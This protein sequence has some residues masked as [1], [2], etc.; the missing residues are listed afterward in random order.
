MRIANI[1]VPPWYPNQPYLSV[2]LITGILRDKGYYVYQKDINLS[3]YDNLLS[4][5]EIKY[6]YDIYKKNK[7][8]ISQNQQLLLDLEKFLTN[9]TEKIKQKIRD[10]ISYKDKDYVDNLFSDLEL[11]LKLYTLNYPDVEISLGGFK[12]NFDSFNIE[13]VEKYILL[14]NNLF[15][16]YF[17]KY[18]LKDILFQDIDVLAIGITTPEQLLPCFVL[19]DLIKKHNHKIKVLLGGDYLSRVYETIISSNLLKSLFDFILIGNVEKTIID[20]F[21]ALN[22]NI[23]LHNVPSLIWNENGETIRN[24][25]NENFNYSNIVYP[26]FNGLD[27]KKYFSPSLTLPIEVSKGCFWGK[28]NFCEIKGKKYIQKNAEQVI[29][30]INYQNSSFGNTYFSFVSSSPSPKLLYEISSLIKGKDY[31]WSSFIRPEKYIN[32]D[33]A[34]TLYDGGCRLLF[35]GIESGSQNILDLMNKGNDINDII[36]VIDALSKAGI[37]LHGYF[38]FG[39]SG[40]NKSDIEHTIEFINKNINQFNSVSF[41]YYTEPIISDLKIY[42][43]AN[44]NTN[45][46]I[47]LANNIPNIGKKYTYNLN[48]ELYEWI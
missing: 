18:E 24:P 3:F 38:M 36:N 30:E 6:Q 1:N 29:E 8:S 15:K 19:S 7:S 34:K 12:Y 17:E 37:K 5:N 27:L 16:Y 41:S 9:N 43:D 23:D 33:F 22:N 14:E 13:E 20:F 25:I 44:P 35:I 11:A 4:K 48:L 45:L 42:K 40:E 2:P 31:K 10:Y 21:Y 47:E 26:D 39:Y 32:Y 46:I 28:C